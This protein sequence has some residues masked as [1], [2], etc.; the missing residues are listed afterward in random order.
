VYEKRKIGISGVERL[1]AHQVP[2]VNVEGSQSM[3][4]PVP[5]IS[6]LAAVFFSSSCGAHVP[7]PRDL[8]AGTPFVSW[9]LMSGDRDN[10]D[11]DFVCQSEPRNDCVVEAS[12]PDAQAFSDV[13]FYYHSAGGETK[14]QGTIDVGF[15]DGSAAARTA[16]TN[17]VVRKGESMTNQSVT[18]IVTSKPGTYQVTFALT[19]TIADA[20][21]TQPIRQSVQVVVK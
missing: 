4:A 21:T 16:A 2:A 1:P 18:G 15:F 20:G 11:H 7:K 10:P 3:R 6:G 19:A 8:P 17:V 5:V 14:Y 13:H 12:R 9:V